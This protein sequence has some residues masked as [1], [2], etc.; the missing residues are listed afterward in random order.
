M[1][2]IVLQQKIQFIRNRLS[3]AIDDEFKSRV[4]AEQLKRYEELLTNI[5][6]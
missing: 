1:Q 6:Q 5:N 4:Y 2:A 3:Q